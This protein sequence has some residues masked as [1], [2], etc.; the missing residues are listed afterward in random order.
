MNLSKKCQSLIEEGFA[1][2]V[3]Y[4]NGFAHHLPMALIALDRMNAEEG[5]LQCFSDNYIKILNPLLEKVNFKKIISIDEHLGNRAY[6]SAYL[7]FF[8]D[9]ISSKGTLKVIEKSIPLLI[10]SPSSCAFHCLIRTSYAISSDIPHEIAM[11]L[12]YWASEFITFKTEITIEKKDIIGELE[13]LSIKFHNHKFAQGNISVRMMEVDNLLSES[14]D[15][16]IFPEYSLDS[17]AELVLIL[18]AQT[19]NFTLLHA[20]TSTHAFRTLLPYISDKD[21]ALKYLW[22]GIVLAFLSTGIILPS[23][24]PVYEDHQTTWKKIF[25]KAVKS[26]DAHTIKLVYTSWEEWKEYDNDLYIQIAHKK[27]N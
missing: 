1:Y 3:S 2:S 5:D 19:E 6:F 4:A 10:K 8:K 11:A 16:I 23:L 27:V 13:N 17:I 18:Y 12:A 21:L 20:V 25:R 26:T 9:E 22:Q 7:N 24:S 15:Y 14:K